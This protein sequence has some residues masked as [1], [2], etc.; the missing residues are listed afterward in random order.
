MWSISSGSTFV[1]PV[2]DDRDLELVRLGHRDPLAVRVDDE[3]GARHAL[4]LAHPADRQRELGHLVGE[5]RGFLLRHPLEVA[6]LLARLELLEEGDPLLDRR[7]VR[8]HAA[9]PALVDVRLAGAGRLL[10]DRLLGL[11]LRP[12]EQDVLAAGD[13]LA[14]E[15]ERRVEVLDG[16]GEIDDVDPVALGE[17]ERA[18]LGIPAARLVAEVD[19]GFQ[20]LPHRDGRHGAR[21]PVRFRSSAD[22]VAGFPV[23]RPRR[24]LGPAPSRSERSACD[25]RDGGSTPGSATTGAA[26]RRSVARGRSTARWLHSRPAPTP[27][28][29]RA[30][31]RG[32]FTG[33]RLCARCTLRRTSGAARGKQVVFEGILFLRVYELRA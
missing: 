16:L 31:G 15:I 7:E 13:R 24:V 6:G 33:R 12:D 22:L 11:L 4:H 26:A 21:P 14:H 29:E 25:L 2:A 1:S 19:S 32:T 23:R 18:H 27:R 30:S 28:G 3:D 10:G 20:Q 17:D 9:E 5:L 8:Q